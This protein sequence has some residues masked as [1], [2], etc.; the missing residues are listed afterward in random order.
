[1]AE[2]NEE[3]E[4]VEQPEPV[5]PVEPTEPDEGDEDEDAK[6]ADPEPVE[7]EPEPAPSGLTEKEIEARFD[8]IARE[9]ERHAKRVGE[10]LEEDATDLLMCPLCSSFIG[11][12][13]LNA[14]VADEPR[15]ATLGFLGVI[16]ASELPQADYLERCETCKGRGEVKT[17]STRPG[18]EAANCAACEGKGYRNAGAPVVLNG[19]MSPEYVAPHDNPSLPPPADDPRI[20]EMQRDGYMVVKVPTPGG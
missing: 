18:Y 5:E 10:I 20:A 4:Q 15:A 2:V 17:G 12:F 11:G 7:P 13:V 14:P 9:N 16:D 3:A 8:K 19:G 1:M 6:Q